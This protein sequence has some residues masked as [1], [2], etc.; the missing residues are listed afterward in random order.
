M[1]AIK[2]TN[3][4][5]IR[6]HNM[7]KLMLKQ[8][9]SLIFNLLFIILI[10]FYSC[11]RNNK[12]TIKHFYPNGICSQEYEINEDSLK[13]GI[14][15]EYYKSGKPYLYGHYKNGLLNG[16]IVYQMNDGRISQILYYSNGI[17][18]SG[19]RFDSSGN[20]NGEIFQ[21]VFKTTSNIVKVGEKFV[22]NISLTPQPQ[23][24]IGTIEL[25]LNN[26]KIY[27]SKNVDAGYPV[28]TA[29]FYKDYNFEWRFPITGEYI[30]E[31]VIHFKEADK[32]KNYSG[33]QYKVKV[34][35]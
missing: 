15:I 34:L 21:T 10:I 31:C 26:A 17:Y 35:P 16:K 14:F 19:E 23:I 22:L 2:M 6:L 24:S 8:W 27:A 9:Q 30:I 25:Y 12:I 18:N 11:T 20:F 3:L 29:Q 33:G 32:S 1:R 5:V 7:R 4:L 28:I 13:D